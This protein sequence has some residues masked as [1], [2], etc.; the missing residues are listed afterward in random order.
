[1][2]QQQSAFDKLKKCIVKLPELA[3]PDNA[4]PYDIHSDASNIGIGAVLV[5]RG[6]PI[7]SES[8]TLIVAE[9]NYSTTEK[10]CMA[11]VWALE[12][13][14]P[15]VHGADFTVFTDHVALRSILTNKTPL[16]RIARWIMTIQAYKFTVQHKKG[17]LNGDADA[18]SRIQNSQRTEPD[19]LLTKKHL[20]ISKAE[21]KL[22]GLLENRDQAPFNIKHGT[23]STEN[24][25][26]LFYPHGY[27]IL[28]YGKYMIIQR[29]VILVELRLEIKQDNWLLA[30][31][32]QEYRRLRT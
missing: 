7:A 32:G 22:L 24:R 20:E 13:F 23:Y 15:Y 5:Q 16:G 3:H 8:R 28:Y 19:L 10:E 30:Q 31:H 17:S 2:Q 18:P 27:Q 1:V 11:V 6:R 25:Q 29:P 12:Q 4:L 21:T 9:R 14:H 26:W